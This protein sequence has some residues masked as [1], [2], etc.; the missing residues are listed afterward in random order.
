MSAFD[1]ESQTTMAR[2]S[3]LPIENLSIEFHDSSIPLPQDLYDVADGQFGIVKM[4]VRGDISIPA[5]V[6]LVNMEKDGSGSMT[7]GTNDG[8]TRDEHVK[9]T[10]CNA[11]RA[12]TKIA[13]ENPQ[14]QLFVKLADFDTAVYP[15]LALTQLSVDNMEQLVSTVTERKLPNNSTNIELALRNSVKSCDEFLAE[16]PGAHIISVITT[17]GEANSGECN[18]FKLQDIVKSSP[19]PTICIGYG[20]G[21]NAD[22]LI[23]VGSSYFY[24][25]DF[26][27]A[28]EPI[29][30]ILQNF[31]YIAMEKSEL[32]IL[33]G[34]ILHEDQTWR[35]KLNLG[36]IIGGTEKTYSVRSKDPEAVH[37]L[38]YGKNTQTTEPNP[39]IMLAESAAFTCYK[40]LT[41]DI[42]RHK[43]VELLAQA[44]DNLALD[45]VAPTHPQYSDNYAADMER[46]EGEVVA[47]TELVK[48][49]AEQK[50]TLRD[51][52]KVFFRSMKDYAK[53]KNMENEALMKQLLDD[54]YTV[55]LSLGSRFTQNE[56]RAFTQAKY[57][58]NARQLSNNTSA[59]SASQTPG[60]R[61]QNAGL[62]RQNAI[63]PAYDN[64]QGGVAVA[65]LRPP[66]LMRTPTCMTH[67]GMEDLEDGE[68]DEEDDLVHEL[69]DGAVSAYATQPTVAL[70][71]EVSSARSSV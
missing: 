60:L 3:S 36:N 63:S 69:T 71:R 46:Y 51:K 15:V 61:R 35:N 55:W 34:E 18:K 59:R 40:D 68:V 42:F 21:H 66:M 2:S 45:L 58:C 22:L 27:R 26:E 31:L 39:L 33:N 19:Y 4:K 41:R 11:I 32:Q 65:P 53:D 13:T 25:A 49:H 7:T 43:T 37:A 67:P 62:Q 1:I 30:E 38:L 64:S 8:R 54:V 29:G 52:L 6:Y 70:M 5:G 10:I 12:L 47:Y 9:A 20:A 48:S 44:R 14:V 24:V 23:T 57:M 17:D 50:K 16:N 56:A 28:G